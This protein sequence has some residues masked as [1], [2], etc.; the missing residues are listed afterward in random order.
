MDEATQ[1]LQP[2]NVTTE[3]QKL[4]SLFQ[5][6][7]G[8]LTHTHTQFHPDSDWSKNDR[9]ILKRWKGEGGLIPLQF[10]LPLL[11]EVA[12]GLGGKRGGFFVID[13][14]HP[15]HS[16]KEY[17]N[18]FFPGKS[19]EEVRELRKNLFSPTKL[20]ET[21]T[22]IS[23]NLDLRR[24]AVEQER[25]KRNLE[26]RIFT[27]VEADI[28]NSSGRLDVSLNVLSQLD[29]VTASFHKGEW[30]DVNGKE[31]SYDEILEAYLNLSSSS[32]IDVIGHPE[33]S[34][35][36]LSPQQWEKW[37]KIFKNL[38]V[39]GTCLEIAL[40]GLIN[41]ETREGER[42]QFL[43]FLKRAKSA[44]VGLILNVDF[45]RL[46]SFFLD[47]LPSGVKQPEAAKAREA[48]QTLSE[49]AKEPAEGEKQIQAFE[50]AFKTTL[51]E[52]FK[53]G[54]G[55]FGLP[56]YFTTLARPLYYGIKQLQEAGITPEDIVNGDI[57]RFQTWVL[58]RKILKKAVT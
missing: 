6:W 43:Q 44:G 35:E 53:E 30:V 5:K 17:N 15:A 8:V 37:E 39:R 52:I 55:A 16:L 19:A 47:T 27:G 7:L 56:K 32:S 29:V 14:P 46:E 54:E 25:K 18:D 38:A 13:T 51:A 2:G 10:S 34:K 24:R 4:P 20:D 31:P 58:E 45:H 48:L 50:K 36:P 9:E 57:G 41:P 3:P 49:K 26:N 21:I 33:L 42:S 12:E 11:A 23:E 28:L 40:S 1:E 22:T